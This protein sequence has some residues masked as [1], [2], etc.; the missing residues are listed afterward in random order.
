MATEFS[1]D[2]RKNEP[3]YVSLQP[4]TFAEVLRRGIFRHHSCRYIPCEIKDGLYDHLV[5]P[6]SQYYA[7]PM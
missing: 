5:F 2:I 7:E 4:I 3:Q 1:G 6:D